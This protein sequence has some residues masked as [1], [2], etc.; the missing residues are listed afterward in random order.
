[1]D[2]R[3]VEAV[4]VISVDDLYAAQCFQQAVRVNV[5]PHQLDESLFVPLA[6]VDADDRDFTAGRR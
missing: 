2:K 1:M 6:D 3:Q 4:A 5:L